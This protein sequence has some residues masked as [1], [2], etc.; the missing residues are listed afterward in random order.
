VVE[1]RPTDEA[2]PEIRFETDPALQTQGDWT[3]CGTWP[4]ADGATELFAWVAILGYSRMVAVRFA[5]DKTRPTTLERIVRCVDDLGGATADFLP[6]RDTVLVSGRRADDRP[7][8]AP[9]WVDTAACGARLKACRAYRAK[10]KGKVERIIREVK[11]DFLAWLT[12]QPF[13]EHPTLAWYDEQAR[14]WALTVVATRRCS[15]GHPGS[16]RATSR[17]PSGSPPPRPAT[18]PT[19]RPRPTSWRRLSPPI[20]RAAGPA[21]CGPTP[22]RR[23]W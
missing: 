1:L 17:S 14:C 10:T 20:S 4:L 2:E 18:G 7:I 3:D 8:F 12:G 6:D 21:R 9:E 5:T 23:C 19:S 16:A 22:A 13:P 15:W 11:E